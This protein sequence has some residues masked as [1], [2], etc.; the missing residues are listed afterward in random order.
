MKTRKIEKY[1]VNQRLPDE[2]ICKDSSRNM[3]SEQMITTL[4]LMKE[5]M[6]MNIKRCSEFSCFQFCLL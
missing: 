3:N 1:N 4:N 6:E 5:V 2:C